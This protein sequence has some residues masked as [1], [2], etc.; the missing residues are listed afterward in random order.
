[1]TSSHFDLLLRGGTVIDGTRRPRFQ[2]DVG[3]AH[4]RIAAIGDLSGATADHDVDAGGRV[5][6]PGFI[7][8]HT[9]DDQAVLSQPA[10]PFKLSQ[11][12]TTVVTGNCGISAAPL[13][14]D[15]PL[16]MPLNLIDA[17]ARGRF[18]SFAAYFAALRTTPSS[19]NVAAMI[20]HSTLRGLVMDDLDRP[21][22]PAQ[23]D[24][25]RAHVAEAMAAGAIGMSTG[26]FYPTAAH[27]TTEEI[28]EVGRPLGACGA[29]YATHLRDESDGIVEALEE[30][31]TIGRALGVPVVLSH[32]KAMHKPNF[33][34]T[35]FTL[36][37]IRETM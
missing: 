31:F 6:A 13:R 1:M 32:H 22:T 27:A 23:V 16:P 9:H 35:Q 20:G 7:D 5:V 34:R 37:L 14:D 28:I 12:V 24:A 15:M 26:T 21:A 29:V 8:A 11:G 33:G 3:V 4:G 2:A 30:A 10:M 25:M 17:P 18:G 36:P 19:V